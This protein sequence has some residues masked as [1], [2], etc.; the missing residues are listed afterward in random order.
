MSPPRTQDTVATR[1]LFTKLDVAMRRW[2]RQQLGLAWN[3]MLAKLEAIVKLEKSAHRAAVCFSS[4]AQ[5]KVLN[6]WTTMRK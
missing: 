1:S 5:R 2:R 3:F 4:T 6:T